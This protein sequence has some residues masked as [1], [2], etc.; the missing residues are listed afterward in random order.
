MRGPENPAIFLYVVMVYSL[1][2]HRCQT[3][4]LF[5]YSTLFMEDTSKHCS[6]ALNHQQ[7]RATVSK[8]TLQNL[9]IGSGRC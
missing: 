9:I 5:A 4:K 1:F 8:Q 6:E 7:S 3:L 2:V